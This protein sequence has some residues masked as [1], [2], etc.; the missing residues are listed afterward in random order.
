MSTPPP[1]QWSACH[2][3]TIRRY[4]ATMTCS[5]GHTLTLRQHV[6]E[7]DGTVWPSVRCPKKGLS[8]PCI[9]PFEQLDL[10]TNHLKVCLAWRGS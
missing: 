2:P 5:N 10:W 6:I 3:S 8:L 4:K 9:R 7:R 1:M